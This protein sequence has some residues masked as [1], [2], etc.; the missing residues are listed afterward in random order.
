MTQMFGS[1]VAVVWIDPET[2]LPRAED[3]YLSA[4]SQVECCG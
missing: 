4:Y 3:Y 2:N 1:D